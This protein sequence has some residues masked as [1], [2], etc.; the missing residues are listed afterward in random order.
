MKNNVLRVFL[1]VLHF[2]K[3]LVKMAF[4]AE[5]LRSWHISPTETVKRAFLPISLLRCFPQVQSFL[6][7]SNKFS[8]DDYF[9]SK[10]VHQEILYR[11]IG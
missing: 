8:C 1:D 7:S 6:M 2:Q 4:L 9:H 3:N 5:N 10:T 11:M